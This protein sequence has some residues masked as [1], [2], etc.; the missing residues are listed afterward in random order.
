MSSRE[1]DCLSAMV[2]FCAVMSANFGDTKI[3]RSHCLRLLSVLMEIDGLENPSIL[4]VDAF[5][6]LIALTFSLPSLFSKDNAAPLPSGNVQDQHLLKLIYLGMFSK[7][8][9][10]KNN[11]FW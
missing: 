11:N 7:K 1:K 3:V 4:D 8:L 2:R 10:V 5:G 9:I 6:F